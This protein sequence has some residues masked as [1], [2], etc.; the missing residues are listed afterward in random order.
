MLH[1]RMITT[2]NNSFLRAAVEGVGQCFREGYTLV[3]GTV[4]AY[5]IVYLRSGAEVK[6]YRQKTNVEHQDEERALADLLNE[7]RV[8]RE[9]FV[10]DLSA[11]SKKR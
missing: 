3:N 4:L 5:F 1:D 6:V 8:E 7:L 10:A 9:R 2:G 11:T